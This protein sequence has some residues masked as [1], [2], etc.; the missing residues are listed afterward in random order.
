MRAALQTARW[1][2]TLNLGLLA[3]VGAWFAYIDAAITDAAMLVLAVGIALSL[4]SVAAALLSMERLL[5]R[6]AAAPTG[7]R[8]RRLALLLLLLA[9]VCEL[10]AAT[11]TLNLKGG[12]SDA[13]DTTTAATVPA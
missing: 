5:S 10:G 9:L 8:S 6:V 11:A 4:G 12:D 3:G 1:I 2:A 13:S 7:V